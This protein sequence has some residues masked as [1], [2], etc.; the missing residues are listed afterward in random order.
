MKNVSCYF[1]STGK[2]FAHSTSSTE[3]TAVLMKIQVCRDFTATFI[4][5]CRLLW[6]Y[7]SLLLISPV[8]GYS[9]PLFIEADPPNTSINADEEESGSGTCLF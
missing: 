9:I 1:P 8:R 5:M 4:M 2:T 6:K 7:P 3:Y